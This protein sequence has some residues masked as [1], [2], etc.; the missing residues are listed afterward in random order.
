MVQALIAK[1]LTIRWN[2]KV[3]AKRGEGSLVPFVAHSQAL[4]KVFGALASLVDHD[5]P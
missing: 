4:A 5:I 2:A 3:M 1:Q